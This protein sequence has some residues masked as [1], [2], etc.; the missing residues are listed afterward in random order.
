[1][2]IANAAVAQLVERVAV[3]HMVAGSNPAGGALPL[4]AAENGSI[5]EKWFFTNRKK[6]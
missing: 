4:V 3:N 6:I 5:C 2:T 1:V